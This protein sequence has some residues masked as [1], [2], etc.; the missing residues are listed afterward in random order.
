MKTEFYQD[1]AKEW[2]WRITAANGEIVA[3]SSEGFKSE[4]GAK[5]NYRITATAMTDHLLA[6]I[7]TDMV[8]DRMALADGDKGDSES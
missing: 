3:A 5:S 7:V 6:D 1:N 4:G 8:A 2:R